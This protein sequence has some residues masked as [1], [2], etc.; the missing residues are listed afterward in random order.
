MAV[1]SAAVN[2]AKLAA[3]VRGLRLCVNHADRCLVRGVDWNIGKV[4]SN[5]QP[6]YFGF[7]LGPYS[8][9]GT[10]IFLLTIICSFLTTARLLPIKNIQQN[11]NELCML[12]TVLQ[13]FREFIHYL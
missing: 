1:R 8:I 2:Q 11:E 3:K 13:G 12:N 4:T 5:Y 10:G 7:G 9:S 6:A